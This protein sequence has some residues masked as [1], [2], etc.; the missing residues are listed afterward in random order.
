MLYFVS[1]LF[2]IVTSII[3]MLAIVGIFVSLSRDGGESLNLKFSTLD[4]FLLFTFLL[5][6]TGVYLFG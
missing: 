6:G 5:S 2:F 3:W 4:A 1:A